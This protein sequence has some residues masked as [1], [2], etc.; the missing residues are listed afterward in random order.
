M[1]TGKPSE[2]KVLESAAAALGIENSVE[3]I[4]LDRK[5]L[6][7]FTQ[8]QLFE[9]AKRLQLKGVSKLSKE[10]LAFRVADEFSTR[11]SPA[12]E[13]RKARPARGEQ[14][15]KVEGEKESPDAGDGSDSVLV[16]QVRGARACQGRSTVDDS[17][18]PT[19]TTA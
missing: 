17:R 4:K 8:R 15:P 11:I 19:D 13:A 16:A 10:E 18:G 2:D 14:L 3:L 12:P 1:G 5:S 7:R 6:S 9:C